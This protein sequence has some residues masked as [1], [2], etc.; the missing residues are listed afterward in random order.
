[1][2]RLS[3]ARKAER[4]AEMKA[5]ST[6]EVANMVATIL[7]YLHKLERKDGATVIIQHTLSRR[8]VALAAVAIVAAFLAVR[9][10]T[11]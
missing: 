1:M 8:A 5:A 6:I 9:Y 4:F 11:P 10:V 3:P 7:P 2:T